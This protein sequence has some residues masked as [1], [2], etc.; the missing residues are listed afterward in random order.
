MSLYKA[1]FSNDIGATAGTKLVGMLPAG[2]T[3]VT[4]SSDNIKESSR[5]DAVYTSI[6]DIPLESASVEEGKVILTFPQQTKDIKVI[7]IL[8]AT[9]A[10]GA[11][12]L[13]GKDGIQGVDGEPGAD[14]KSAYQYAVD[15][16]Y[17]G[18][19]EEFVAL[20]ANMNN[21]LTTEDVVNNLTSTETTLPLS[22]NMGKSLSSTISGL[23]AKIYKTNYIWHYYDK[24]TMSAGGSLKIE[25]PSR[26]PGYAVNYAYVTLEISYTHSTGTKVFVN[27]W[28]FDLSS[29]SSSD[30]YSNTWE[31][32]VGSAKCKVAATR[33]KYYMNITTLQ[34]ASSSTASFSNIAGTFRV[35]YR[36]V[37]YGV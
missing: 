32:S 25:Y 27:E 17:E 35:Y 34:F 21:A 3:T 37:P 16:G 8:D 7:A 9:V 4:I 29:Y 18:T 10:N 20:M 31:F 19:E 15:G 12:G 6:Y 11:D 36:E 22:A 30:S 1:T 33:T 24:L 26:M 13:D 14:G 2:E 28:E 23:P 5:L